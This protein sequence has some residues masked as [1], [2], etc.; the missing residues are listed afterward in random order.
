MHKSTVAT[1]ESGS[2]IVREWYLMSVRE[3]QSARIYG[4]ERRG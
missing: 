1:I 3:E 2:T 4:Q